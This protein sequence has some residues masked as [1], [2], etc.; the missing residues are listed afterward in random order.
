MSD[1]VEHLESSAGSDAAASYRLCL[2]CYTTPKPEEK[3]VYE[4]CGHVTCKECLAGQVRSGDL[5]LKCS[6]EVRSAHNTSFA[7]Y[8]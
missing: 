1:L 8:V 2:I 3:Y 7:L 5:P 4:L 6:V